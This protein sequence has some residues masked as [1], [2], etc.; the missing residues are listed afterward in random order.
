[1]KAVKNVMVLG[2][3]TMGHGVAHAAAAAGFETRLYDVS[4]AAL[5][6][7]RGQIDGILRKAVELGK[8]Q[9]PDADA[10]MARL[11]TSSQVADVLGEAVGEVSGNALHWRYQLL[12]KV[13][14]STYV[15]DFDDWMFLLD[16]RVMLNRARMSK[17]GVDLG[18]VTLSFYKPAD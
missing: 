12:L 6:K 8:L 10:A 4:D 15:V 5:A 13:D 7:A 11:Q 1:M 16:Q 2:A 17:W 3:G 14:G 18:E 9:T